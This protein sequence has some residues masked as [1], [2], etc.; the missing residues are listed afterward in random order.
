MGEHVDYEVAQQP[1]YA[2]RTS[3]DTLNPTAEELKVFCAK[4]VRC[5]RSIYLIW[6]LTCNH[7]QEKEIRSHVTPTGLLFST[8][9]NEAPSFH[10]FFPELEELLGRVDFTRLPYRRSISYEGRF[11]WKTM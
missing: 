6:T 5:D 2:V 8:I 1:I 7:L 4:T 9:S 3:G 11:N 10:D